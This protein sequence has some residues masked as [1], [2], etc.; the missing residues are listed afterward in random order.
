M[1]VKVL[2]LIAAA[3]CFVQISF[4]Q[5]TV[6][7]TQIQQGYLLGPGDVVEGKVL[8]EEQFN[9]IS[10]VDEDGKIQVPFF[11]QG[12]AAKCK[13]EK[14]LKADVT[15]VFSKYLKNPQVSIRVTERHS[16]PPVTISGEV[17]K[18]GQVELTRETRLLEVI[19]FAE[20]TTEDSSGMIQVFRAK[21][22]I[23][24]EME[25]SNSWKDATDNIVNVPSRMYSMSS[26]LL[27]LEASNPII[28]P[29]DLIVVQKAAPIYI[30]G[31]VR[32]ATGMYL[33]EGGLSLMQALSMVGGVNREAKTKQIK[34]YR[35]K[36]NSKERD[37]IIA[38]YD[39]I[40]KGTQK[41]VML[42]PYDIIEVDKAKEPLAKTILSLVTGVGK[43]MIT[44]GANSVGYRILY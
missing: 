38:N 4:G 25:R 6:A 20:G 36:P 43:T 8:G 14:D 11:E 3:I 31:E 17:K 23:C 2:F 9:F 1:K 32:Q 27:G 42:E 40:K 19:T 15:K 10:T 39:L 41:D 13:T 26:V 44:S 24:T 5:Q 21:P 7:A 18:A 22:P 16:R 30:T 29:G 35:L 33:K 37:T 12:V 28:Y 34:I